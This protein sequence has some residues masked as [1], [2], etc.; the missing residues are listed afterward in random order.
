MLNLKRN[1][2]RIDGRGYR[3]YQEIK[4]RYEFEGSTLFI[5]YVQGD[6][7]APPSRIRVRIPQEITGFPRE[8]YEKR[9]CNIALCDFLTRRFEDNIKRFV[10]G[11]RGTGNSGRVTIDYPGQEILPRSSMVVTR[12]YVEARF[13][14][15]LPARGR[16]VLAQAAEA[17]F[18]E[19]LPKLVSY[20]LILRNLDKDQ[21]I[22]HLYSC[23]D[24][25]ALRGELPEKK[26]VAFIANGS[27]LPRASGVDDRPLK[28]GSVIPFKSPIELEVSLP[29]PN[30]GRICGMGI[31]EGVTLIVGGGYHGKTTL[32]RAIERGIYNHIPGDGR[33]KVVSIPDTV[34]IRAEDGRSVKRVDISAFINNLPLQKDTSDFST[35]NASG[36]TSQA[37]N[38]IE[39]LEMGAKLLL[40]DEDTSATN[41]M[42]RDK[43]MQELVAKDKEPITPFVD[44]VGLL[45]KDYGVSTII[46]IG[47]SGDYFDVSN[48][49][50][51]M[52]DYLPKEVTLRAKEVAS[53]YP[54]H[55]RREGGEVFGVIK[56]RVPLAEG[57]DPS[58]GKRGVKISVKDRSTILYGRHAIDLWAVEQLV[59]PSQTRFIASAIHYLTRHMDEKKSLREIITHFMEKIEEKSLD[60][61]FVHGD[62]ALA[63]RHELA[64]A[65]N[66]LRTLKIK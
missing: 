40:I 37:A 17:M 27:I 29:A 53:L 66:R 55:R 13:S 26:L 8:F 45:Y 51:A 52:D 47:G 7:F 32:L 31:P 1:L 39:S 44:K 19:E 60:L 54:T 46:V 58:R 41:F 2:E 42:I 36:S 43:R 59:D 15:G 22:A 20:S 11:N 61:L 64:A 35:E 21:L 3:A 30:S 10:K 12:E 5:D 33:E 25:E 24:Q 57:F 50:I 62:Y 23:E 63:R 38:I 34:K 6:P 4:G 56:G 48:L 65:I 14:M 28:S 49:V 16:R 18:F 9:I